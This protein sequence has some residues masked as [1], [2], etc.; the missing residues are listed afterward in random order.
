MNKKSTLILVLL[1]ITL[2][3]WSQITITGTVI[4]K[5]DNSPFPGAIVKLKGTDNITITDINGTFSL[6]ISDPNGILV[7]SSVGMVTKEFKLNGQNYVF[8][9]IKYDCNIDT[10]DQQ[11]I[12][13]SIN[14]GVINN[15]VGGQ[16]DFS[17]PAFLRATT[18]KT[19]ID[20]QT[21][22]TKN[23]FL[24]TQIEFD[25]VVLKC[26]FQM[27]LKWYYRK[28]SYNNDFKANAYSFEADFIFFNI[29]NWN[30]YDMGLIAGCS[31]LDYEKTGLD[32]KDVSYGP[33]I[34]FR[35]QMG[36]PLYLSIF[37]KISIFEDY[38]EY[39][40]QIH[41]EF[42][43]M[44][45]FIKFYKLDSFT[46]LSLGIGIIMMYWLKKQRKMRQ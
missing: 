29:R 42:K 11:Q 28:I 36:K 35:A 2:N 38:L 37:G 17:F 12:G 30:I 19:R 40:G 13:I 32:T 9:T 39:Q 25:H 15:P 21:D 6:D 1:T 27:D 45:A 44:N 24:N 23:E 10:F 14:S 46:E 16:F 7:V 26:D 8:I 5:D 34:G 3:I 4:C 22:L 18:L 33:L 31:R 20:Y 43:R 41:R